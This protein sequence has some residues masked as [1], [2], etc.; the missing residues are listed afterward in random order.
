MRVFSLTG[1]CRLVP[2]RRLRPR[3]TQDTSINAI[4]TLT[5]LSLSMVYLSRYFN[6][7]LHIMLKS[8]NPASA[9][10]ETVWA[11]PFSLATTRGITIV[12]SSSRYLDVSVPW[13]RFVRLCIQ[14][15]M[16]SFSWPGCPIRKS[17]AQSL[18]SGSPKLIAATYVLHRLLAPRHPPYALS[19]LT[20]R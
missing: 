5:R 1:W 18:C 20:S 4:L 19:S 15:T 14:R 17:P 12:F 3:G 8:Y 10:T 13:V 7:K 9:L 11:L 2:T 16:T 6:L